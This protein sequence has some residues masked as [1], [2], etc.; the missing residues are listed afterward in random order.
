MPGLIE[1]L[2]VSV[3]HRLYR[4]CHRMRDVGSIRVYLVQ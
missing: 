2:A 3:R 1:L 4:N